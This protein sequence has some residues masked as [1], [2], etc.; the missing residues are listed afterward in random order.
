MPIQS[1]DPVLEGGLEERKET[2]RRKGEEEREF[3]VNN[4]KAHPG[5]VLDGTS[6]A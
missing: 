4:L 1:L 6:K 5:D 3:Q 2:R